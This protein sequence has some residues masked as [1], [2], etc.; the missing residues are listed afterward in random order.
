M[1]NTRIIF[2]DH[3]DSCNEA[4]AALLRGEL[5]AFPTDTVYGLAVPVNSTTGIDMLYAAK[6][7]DSNKAIA[8]LIADLSDLA[9]LTPGI[10][11]KALHLAK[12]FWPG[13][14]TLIVPKLPTLPSNLS[15]LPTV[16][17][18]IPN[19]PFA[20]ALLRIT[21]ALATTSANISNQES[22]T[23]ARQVFD[24]LNGRIHLIVDGGRTPGGMSSTVVNCVS[25]DLAILRQGPISLADIQKVL[26]EN[27][28]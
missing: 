15:A 1:L 16:G 11:S 10:S 19:H 26:G 20:R 9:Y 24:Q 22:P 2:S 3:P 8:V 27:P 12:Q 13:P 5:V 7:R 6:G 14:L 28:T 18:R 4:A 21:G 17:V 23:T 25:D